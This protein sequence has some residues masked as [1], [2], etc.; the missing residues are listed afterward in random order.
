LSNSLAC[1]VRLLDE[2]VNKGRNGE[3]SIYPDPSHTHGH[4]MHP[5][6]RQVH[7]HRTRLEIAVAI[8]AQGPTNSS[9]LGGQRS[10]GSFPTGSN[11]SLTTNENTSMSRPHF[12]CRAG[13]GIR[14]AVMI[15]SSS[16]NSC[17][18]RGMPACQGSLACGIHQDV[19]EPVGLRI[20]YVCGT[21]ISLWSAD[22]SNH[23]HRRPFP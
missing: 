3:R 17:G 21:P 11:A 1:I 18:K 2:E 6:P 14:L 8:E 22:V 5:F 20:T 7:H 9:G 15:S 4:D 10:A 19:S 23:G 16:A 13:P 12:T